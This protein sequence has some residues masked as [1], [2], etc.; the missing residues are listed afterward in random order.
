MVCARPRTGRLYSEW[1]NTLER[2]CYWFTDHQ[3]DLWSEMSAQNPN[4]TIR[5]HLPQ[6]QSVHPAATQKYPLTFHHV[7]GAAFFLFAVRLLTS[8]STTL[9]IP[10][11]R[12]SRT[13]EL[14]H[15]FACL[16]NDN[17]LTVFG[18]FSKLFW[19]W[20]PQLYSANSS[21]KIFSENKKQTNKKK[22]P[23]VP[24]L[25]STNGF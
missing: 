10:L 2:H 11:N 16:K 13:R 12:C 22:S 17:K 24:C 20:G 8:S 18:P 25:S 14:Y 23:T 1:L 7:T 21:K 5:Q 19:F 4:D 15:Y 6:P 9:D 3:W